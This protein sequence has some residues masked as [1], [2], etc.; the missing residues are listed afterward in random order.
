[1]EEKAEEKIKEAPEKK[2]KVFSPE[3]ETAIKTRDRTVLVSA[4]AGSG[5]TT[6]LTERIIRSLLDEEKP[7]SIQNMLIVTFTNASVYDLKEKISAALTEAAVENPKLEKELR[8]LDHAKIMTINSFCA[9]F[10]RINANRLGVS[11]AYRIAEPAEA[12]ILEKNVI[13]A[14][15]EAT[16]KGELEPEIN[17]RDFESLCD[18]LTGV[19]NTDELANRF[20]FLYE[21]TKSMLKGCGIF[22]EFADDYLKFSK[23]NVEDTLYGKEAIKSAKECLDYLPNLLSYYTE[24]LFSSGEDQLVALAQYLENEVPRVRLL[25]HGNPTYLEMKERLSSFK[26]G[27]KAPSVKEPKPQAAKLAINYRD[28]IKS[29]ISSL[30]N[31]LFFYSEDEWRELYEKMAKYVGLLGS[32]LKKF[33]AVYLDE[34]IKRGCLE[35]SDTERL[36]YNCLWN[37]DEPSDIAESYRSLF[38]SVYIDEYQDVNELQDKIFEAVAPPTGRFMVGDIKQ[39]IYGYRS[40]RPEIFR[41]MKK[42]FPPLDDEYHR[43]SSIFMSNNYRCDEGII[44]FVH[45]VFDGL[46]GATRESIEYVDEDKLKYE[47]KYKDFTPEYE[48]A[49]IWL[50]PQKSGEKK[51]ATT[52]TDAEEKSNDLFLEPKEEDNEEDLSL[53]VIEAELVADKIKDLIDNGKRRDGS[54]ITPADV[55]IL[56]KTKKRFSNFEKA[57]AKRGIKASAPEDKDFFMNK[58]IL[59][60]LSLLSSIDNPKKDVYLAALMCSPLYGFTADELYVMKTEGKASTLYDSLLNYH[61]SKPEF[62]KLGNFLKELAHYRIL[63]EGMTIDALL[64]RLYH[65]TGLLSLAS[66]QGGRE[67]LY[68]LYSYARKFEGSLYK[69]LYNFITFVSNLIESDATFDSNEGTQKREDSV[70]IG[71]IHSAKGLEFPVVF[72]ADAGASLVNLDTREKIAFSEDFGIS[73]LL[74]AP[75]GLALVDTPLHHVILNYMNG[76]YYEELIRLLYVA[77]TRAKEKLFVVGKCP[78]KAEEYLK[79]SKAIGSSLSPYSV[80]KFKNYL[81]M[82]CATSTKAEIEICN[83]DEIGLSKTEKKEK[84]KANSSSEEK[85]LGMIRSIE[86]RFAFKYPD[87]HLTVMPEKVSVSKLHPRILDGTDDEP[88]ETARKTVKEEEENKRAPVPSFISEHEADESAKK[89]IATHNFLQFFDIGE[90]RKNGGKAECERL[91]KLGF[92]SEKNAKRIRL[93]EISKFERSELLSAMEN[94]KNLYREFRFNTR[95]P[96]ELFTESEEN[97]KLYEGHTVLVQGVIDCLIENED[98]SFRL[99][100]YK[101]DRLT[102]EEKNDETLAQKKLSEKHSRQLHYYALAVEKIF[103]KKPTRV[104]VYSL[105]LGKT[106]EV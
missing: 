31:S 33:S 86:E 29:S 59:L 90:L 36:T 16:Y 69:G 7:E 19:K 10:V 41:D 84:T 61:K 103:G 35:F 89:G 58:E 64:S 25:A 96:A 92:L 105:P 37:G 40:A 43:E 34:K 5:K 49:H 14:L 24:P 26:F 78:E 101:T 32:F 60:T 48:K 63:S 102:E 9:E 18:A 106:V 3:Q 99:V 95:L 79:I 98:G 6:T 81:D 1:M 28:K 87:E 22:S 85:V 2:K 80:K 66:R 77:L 39:S 65:E 88:D 11:P 20:I 21:K 83:T 57:L 27:G 75:G 56:L 70:H 54:K 30:T 42:S 68:R 100:D 47:K 44:D 51:D 74:R 46:F 76:K 91:E 45:E 82:V 53:D 50:I 55:A 15:I 52:D 13:E 62:T 73:F 8:A 23:M 104:E 71:T 97:K 38:T 67:N 4:A 93:G 17:A 94:A 12:I 72:L